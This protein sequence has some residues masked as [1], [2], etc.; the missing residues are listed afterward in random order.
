MS[1]TVQLNYYITDSYYTTIL[2]D[3]YSCIYSL[4]FKG[5]VCITTHT[6]TPTVKPNVNVHLYMYVRTR[7]YMC[8]STHTLVQATPL[9]RC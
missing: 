7:M 1:F 8:A 2:L 9:E 4:I 5:F 6:T 3:S